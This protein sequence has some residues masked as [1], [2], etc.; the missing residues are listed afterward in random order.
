MR[1]PF[2]LKWAHLV[3]RGALIIPK[4]QHFCTLRTYNQLSSMSASVEDISISGIFWGV[5]QILSILRL[6][7]TC[8]KTIFQV[9]LGSKRA[10]YGQYSV[11]GPNNF[12]KFHFLKLPTPVSYGNTFI[13][14]SSLYCFNLVY[15]NL[16]YCSVINIFL[17]F[18]LQI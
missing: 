12:Q 9:T 10:L 6:F 4:P 2:D 17:Y 13:K 7:T 18:Y 14:H 3:L 8:S 1:I 11:N 16:L 5:R 15:S